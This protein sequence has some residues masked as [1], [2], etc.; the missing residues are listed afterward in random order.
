MVRLLDLRH[1]VRRLLALALQ[2]LLFLLES[3]LERP[4]RHLVLEHLWGH[5]P[6]QPRVR[7]RPRHLSQPPRHQ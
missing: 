5:R 2:R 6:A 7:H 1:R 4:A 3:L